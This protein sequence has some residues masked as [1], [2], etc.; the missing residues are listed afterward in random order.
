[1]NEILLF[2][3]Q[4]A[5]VLD[6]LLW[7]L[8][9]GMPIALGMLLY[10]QIRQ[11]KVLKF[12]LSQLDR[13]KSHNVE[14]DFILKAMRLAVWHVDA[15]N[16][17]ITYEKDYRENVDGYAPP[18]A[19]P[20]DELVMHYDENDRERMRKSFYEICR[21]DR[22]E[23]H[24][25]YRIY[26]W[27]SGNTYWAE[28]FATVAE[29]DADGKPLKIVGASMRIDKRKDMEEALV[30][31][32]I[33]AEE[34]DR[35]K[36]AF[37]A[38]ISHEIRTPLNAIVGFTS[39]LPDVEGEE[40]NELLNLIRENTQKLLRIVDDVVKISKIEAGMDELKL[41]I[42]DLNTVLLQAAQVAASDTYPGVEIS[43]EFARNEQN[44]STDLDRLQ[45]IIRHLLSNATKFTE[46]GSIV[47]GYN[48][49]HDGRIRI[50][51]RDTGKGI[52]D[53]LQQRVFERFFKVDEFVPGAGLG[54]SVC[55]TMVF[56]LGGK[57][58][59]KSTL[60]SGSKFWFEIPFQ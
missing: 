47:I 45:A 38:N 50:W 3:I 14:Y 29:R 18:P 57:I 43:T 42:F 26:S 40:R 60:G 32:R 31:A 44:L 6:I 11:S 16:E 5:L 30:N 56:S 10:L 34:S 4:R 54:L 17:T 48:E 46:Q 55:Q 2:Y 24:E 7:L 8:L 21:G 27:F 41:S 23:I 33:R 37:I 25:E 13:I 15:K 35:L 52:P 36:T 22:D 51:V 59:V 58:G 53:D 20:F 1:M 9:I 12:E 49:P 39:L 19:T 28:T